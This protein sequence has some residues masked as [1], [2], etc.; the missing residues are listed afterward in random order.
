MI[1]TPDPHA[2]TLL[3]WASVAHK[4]IVSRANSSTFLEIGMANFRPI[5]IGTPSDCVMQECE[6]PARPLYER[7]VNNVR[8]SRTFAALRDTPFPKLISSELRVPEGTIK[9]GGR[10]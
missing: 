5:P 1:P 10:A 2:M 3:L 6:Q 7:I 9:L 4:H 8:Q